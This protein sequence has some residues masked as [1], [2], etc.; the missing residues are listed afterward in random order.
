VCI[1]LL[2]SPADKSYFN[3]AKL[4]RTETAVEHYRDK[5]DTRKPENYG[6]ASMAAV[7]HAHIVANMLRNK[8]PKGTRI[9]LA[10]NP[11]DIVCIVTF[12]VVLYS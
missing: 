7:P 3:R 6:F 8:R 9:I 2:S 1:S 11:K 4:K 12:V 5:F 10:P